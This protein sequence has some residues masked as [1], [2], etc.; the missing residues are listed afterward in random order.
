M[1][2]EGTDGFLMEGR[3]SMA[4]ISRDPLDLVGQTIYC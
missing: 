2:V 4:E 1:T 3:S